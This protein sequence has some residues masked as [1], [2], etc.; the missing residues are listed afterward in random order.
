MEPEKSHDTNSV[1]PIQAHDVMT[2]NVKSVGP[3]AS[4]CDVARLLLDN[5][6]SAVPVVNTDGMP[7]GMVSEGDL[8]GRNETDRVARRDWWLTVM[9]GKQPLDDDFCARVAAKDRTARDVM[10]TPCV[11]VTE[12][13]EVGKIARLLA[14]Q[15]IK[16]VPVVRD[17]RI[18][19]IVSRADLLRV[20]AAGPQDAAAPSKGERSGFLRSLFGGYHLPAW[21]TVAGNS[22]AEATSTPHEARL[23]AEDF[24]KLVVDFH[25]GEAQHRAQ[26]RRDA[27]DQ[28]RQNARRLIDAHVSDE[29]WRGMLHHAQAAAENGQTEFLLLRFPNQLC[30][31]GG[32]AINVAEADWAATLRGEAAEIYLRWERDLKHSGFKLSARVLEFPGGKPGDIGLHLAWGERLGT[33]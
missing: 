20:V 10:S 6:I 24:G 12:Q 25:N 31:D 9:T 1:G 27:A 15:H 19:G 18:V 7:V 16:R 32:R 3:Q 33:A 29:E 11:S 23:T 30:L 2:A 22:P 26:T 8:I 17:G 13:T 5:G 4:L 28:R 21:E 14:I